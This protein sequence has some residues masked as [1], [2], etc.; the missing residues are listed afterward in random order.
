MFVH[1][2]LKPD[3]ILIWIGDGKLMD[4][5]EIEENVWKLNFEAVIGDF[6]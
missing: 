5:K 2:D 4:A 6:G 1:K 3:N